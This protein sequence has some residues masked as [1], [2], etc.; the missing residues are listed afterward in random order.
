M[1]EREQGKRGEREREGERGSPGVALQQ[2]GEAGVGEPGLGDADQEGQ[3]HVLTAA[4]TLALV[5]GPVALLTGPGDTRA[6]SSLG[7]VLHTG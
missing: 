7:Q 6:V 1:G 5:D 3:P 4:A 2:L